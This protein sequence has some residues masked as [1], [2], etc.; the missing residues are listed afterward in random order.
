MPTSHTP[1]INTMQ[2]TRLNRN[3]QQWLDGE[4]TGEEKFTQ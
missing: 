2:N 1:F 4:V 3:G